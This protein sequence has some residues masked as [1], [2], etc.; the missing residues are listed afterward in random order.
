MMNFF[1]SDDVRRNPYHW[2]EQVRSASPVLHDPR[3]D[4]WML[5]DYDSVKRAMDD[6]ESFS[7]VVHPP[8]G[9]APDWLVFQDPP[10]HTQ[11]RAVVMRAF[12][13]RAIAGLEPRMRALSRT[14][15][16][17]ATGR[18]TMDLVAD[19]AAPLPVL[20]IAELIGIPLEERTRFIRW[21]HAIVNLSYCIAGGE[22]A[23][24]VIREHAPA[25]AEMLDYITTLAEQRRAEPKDD[26]I[27]RL[28]EA[29]VG[30]EPLS[31]DDL[32]GFFQLLLSAATE[33]TTNLIDNAVL[34]FIENPEQLARLRRQPELLPS[35]IE[36]VV[37]Y[38]SPGQAMFRETTCDVELHG[39]TIPAGKFVL[40]MIGSANRDPRYFDEPDRFDIARNPNP[41]IAFGHG[42]HFCLGAPLARLEAKVALSDLFDRLDDIR[43]AD[44]EPWEPRPALHVHG[45]MRLPI[46]FRARY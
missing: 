40:I 32:L 35:A 27:T 33:T 41:H 15:L 14:L 25:R 8:T 21:S 2:Y 11:S 6:H 39:R 22:A 12:T 23:A 20:V 10:R 31:V 7:S 44:D 24:R 42:I 37:R 45:P 18:D 16:D 38:R 29:K 30:E 36:E 1:F 26:L 5:F 4:M 13:P 17:S 28:V 46:R 43:L 3:S 19:Y 9:R 34:S